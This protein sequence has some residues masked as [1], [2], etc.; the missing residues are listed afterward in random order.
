MDNAGRQES[1][2]VAAKGRLKGWAATLLLCALGVYFIGY[3]SICPLYK[4]EIGKIKS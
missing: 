2:C 3:A 1:K 4:S